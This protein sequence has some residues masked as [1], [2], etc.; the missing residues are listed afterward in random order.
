MLTRTLIIPDLHHHT[1]NADHWLQSI[2]HDRVVFLGDF[3]D[4]YED[5]VEDAA[6]TARWLCRQMENPDAVFLFGNHDLPYRFGG[7]ERVECPG[8]SPAKSDAINGI[9]K[10]EHWN[11]FQLAHAEQGWLLSHAGFHPAWMKDATEEAIL[12]RCGEAIRLA[13]QGLIDPIMGMGDLPGGIRKYGGPLWMDWENFL[14]IKGINQIVGHTSGEQVRT[15]KGIE[16]TNHCIDVTNGKAAILM[17]R[18]TIE[19]IH[20]G[21]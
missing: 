20:A 3:F 4:D 8:F 21:R 5:T 13:H 7:D 10:R 16:S 6:R 18:G 11:R 1:A 17:T 2:E 15:V 14:P 9:L 19:T 12:G